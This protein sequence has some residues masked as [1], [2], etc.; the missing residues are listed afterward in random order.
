[1]STGG[2]K[3]LDILVN[4]GWSD[5]YEWNRGGNYV[6]FPL[7]NPDDS[8]SGARPGYYVVRGTS[9]PSGLIIES[10]DHDNSSY[11]LIHVTR[12]SALDPPR[13][14]VLERGYG[15]DPWSPKT[16]AAVTP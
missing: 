3:A 4:A 16:V 13:V 14:E 12:G 10:N 9:D 1:L 7:A 11:A 2:L 5:I 8:T 6:D 15:L